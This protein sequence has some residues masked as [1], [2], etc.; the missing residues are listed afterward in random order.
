MIGKLPRLGKIRGTIHQSRKHLWQR[1]HNPARQ[2]TPAFLVGCGRSGT[3][4]LVHHLSKSWQL[5]LYNET[6]PAA[7]EQYRLREL[8]VVETLL[9]RSYAQVTLFKPILDTCQTKVLLSRFPTAKVIFAFRH[10]DDVINSSSKA[11]GM[12]SRLMHIQSWLSDDFSEFAVPPPETTKS[13]VRSRWKPSL[14]PE[15]ATALYWLFYNRLYF[16]LSLDKDERVKLVCY[17]S[18]VQN[19]TEEFEN[20]CRF[21]GLQFVPQITEGVFASSIGHSS[22]PNIAPEIRGDCEELRQQLLQHA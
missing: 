12:N 14:S 3:G 9:H 16:D 13:F 2:T 5:T 6:N 20:L 7:F 17:E 10:Y 18:V 15:S 21:M 8:S 19:P 1:W 11:F 4:M 22:P